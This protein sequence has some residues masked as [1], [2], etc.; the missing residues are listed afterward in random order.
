MI[1]LELKS[2]VDDLERCCSRVEGSGGRITFQGVLEDRRYDTGARE[3]ARRD[4]VLRTRTYRDGDGVRSEIDWKG[5]TAYVNGYKQREEI[6]CGIE[7]PEVM[8]D[9]LERLGLNVSMAIDREIWQYELDGATIRFER[10]PRMDDLVEVEGSPEAIER[11]IK[12]LGLPRAG[13]STDRLGSFVRRYESRTGARAV[14][15]AG[16]RAEMFDFDPSDA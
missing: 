16:A 7:A 6:G 15:A 9:I 8:V 2:V 3:L 13:F 4:H 5:P 11:A 10:Y 1:E 12:V 14:L